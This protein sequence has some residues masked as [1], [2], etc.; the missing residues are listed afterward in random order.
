MTARPVGRRR[1]PTIP[2][3]G[4]GK[5]RAVLLIE[6]GESLVRRPLR[7][8]EKPAVRQGD[9]TGHFDRR[10]GSV[11]RG[12]VPVAVSGTAVGVGVT[13]GTGEDG[14]ASVAVGLPWLGARDQ[15]AAVTNNPKAVA[16]PTAASTRNAGVIRL[17]L[18]AIRRI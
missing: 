6:D 1:Q 16:I 18:S 9:G 7:Q 12:R 8:R 13:P 14:A 3:V 2:V 10:N 17:Y 15:A 11:R 4:G 5:R